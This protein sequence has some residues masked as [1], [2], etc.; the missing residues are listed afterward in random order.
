[1]SVKRQI[2]TPREHADSHFRPGPGSGVVA[3]LL[4]FMGL[5]TLTPCIVLPEWQALQ[6]LRHAERAER[7]RLE[8]MQRVVDR[9]RWKLDAICNDPAVIARLAQ[10]DLRFQRPGEQAVP[11]D[12]S[13]EIRGRHASYTPNSRPPN[14][15]PPLVAAYRPDA[16]SN[17]VFCDEHSRP[18]LIAM[19]V[20]LIGVALWRPA[21]GPGRS[22]GGHIQRELRRVHVRAG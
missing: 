5:G 6:E 17:S 14:T 15:A 11:V 8:A 18:I 10:R 13:R 1:M 20:A 9:E 16:A 2:A 7:D 12:V 4:M 19:S 22:G 21:G 3:L